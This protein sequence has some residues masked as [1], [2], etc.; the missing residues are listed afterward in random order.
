M[1]RLTVIALLLLALTQPACI[2]VGGY[3][4]RGGWFVWPGGLGLLL[5]VVVVLLL[6]RRRGGRGD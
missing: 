1:K 2:V 3:S 4:N 5:L 6:V